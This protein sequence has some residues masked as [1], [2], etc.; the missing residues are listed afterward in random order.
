MYPISINLIY[1]DKAE[2][3][4]ALKKQQS[5]PHMIKKEKKRG[6]GKIVEL[7]LQSLDRFQLTLSNSSGSNV[8]VGNTQILR[9]LSSQ[10][11]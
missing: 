5:T 10:W 9:R 6:R 2:W 7:S 11:S 8:I 1:P 3:F 4:A